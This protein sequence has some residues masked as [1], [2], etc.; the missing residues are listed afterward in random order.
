MRLVQ[1]TDTHLLAGGAQF[2]GVSDTEGALAAAAATI[3][4]IAAH[5][6]PVDRVLVTG[7]LA[8]DG[9]DDAYA[10]FRRLIDP[11][12]LPVSVIPGNHDDRERLR[13]AFADLP[14]MPAAGP[15]RWR[16]EVGGATVVGLDSLVP[17]RTGGAL[18]PGCLDW[19]AGVLAELEGRPLLLAVHHPPVPV[20]IGFMDRIGLAEPE[21]LLSALARR[22]GPTL[23]VAGHV[24]RCVLC[25][26]GA[27]AVVVAPSPAH[28]IGFWNPTDAPVALIEEPG[29][30]L[31]HELA[32]APAGPRF[33]S[34]LVPVGR[35]PVHP[36]G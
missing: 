5:R 32:E 15:I 9:S 22:R 2:R 25:A 31:V 3:G 16:L 6:G 1:L 26:G 7:D 20:G 28:A 27:P 35:W 10:R 12:G 21:P 18:A 29:G 33:V 24:H 19:L 14:E 4:E 30:I 8:E 17:G 34:H 13:A 23:V 36:F 11:L